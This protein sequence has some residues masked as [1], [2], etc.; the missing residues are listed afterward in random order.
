M[1]L[2]V[3]GVGAAVVGDMSSRP[4]WG[5]NEL[6]FVFSTLIVGSIMNFSLM[7]LLAPT[8]AK[9]SAALPKNLLARLFDERTLTRMGAP[10]GHIF[11]RGFSFGGRTINLL[12]KTVMFGTIGFF[13]G[14]AG[15]L[16]TIMHHV[17]IRFLLD[18][19]GPVARVLCY[20]EFPACHDA[21]E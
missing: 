5:L 14:L 8:G 7:Y 4:N 10:G 13:A 20:V 3:L 12:Y 11:E 9:A 1:M 2:Q 6:D 19:S 18:A 15:A 16:S 17:N 21:C